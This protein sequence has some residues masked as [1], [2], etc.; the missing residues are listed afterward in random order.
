MS[1]RQYLINLTNNLIAKN[2]Y[3][4]VFLSRADLRKHIAQDLA[5][6]G[7]IFKMSP[8]KLGEIM[9]AFDIGDV[10]ASKE[11]LFALVHFAGDPEEMLR[12]LVSSCLAFYIV[13]RL[14]DDESHITPYRR[15]PKRTAV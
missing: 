8:A 15:L 1:N 12:E 4:R 9:A 3:Y 14:T 5:Y 7:D 6:G 11:E 2:G 13:S 10:M